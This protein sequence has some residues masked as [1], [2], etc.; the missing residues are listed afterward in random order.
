MVDVNGHSLVINR[1]PVY[2]CERDRDE[3]S[4]LFFLFFSVEGNWNAVGCPKETCSEN[5]VLGGA[6]AIQ[7]A[8]EGA[9]VRLEGK[10]LW[11]CV[12]ERTSDWWSPSPFATTHL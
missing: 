3:G 7:A 6:P 12:N 9:D 2:K 5:G 4:G 8:T 10:H 11:R 1:Y